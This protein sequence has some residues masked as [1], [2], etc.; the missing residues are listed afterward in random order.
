[1]KLDK[2]IVNQ[3]REKPIVQKF[4]LLHDAC[5]KYPSV[6]LKTSSKSKLS[7]ERF[8]LDFAEGGFVE[9]FCLTDLERNEVKRLRRIKK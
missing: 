8:D 7:L 1:M 3:R 4:S 6:V 9:K 5:K 2:D